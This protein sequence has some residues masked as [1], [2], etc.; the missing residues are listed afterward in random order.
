MIEPVYETSYTVKIPVLNIIRNGSYCDTILFKEY[1]GSNFY[2]D[3]PGRVY[4]GDNYSLLVIENYLAFN[5]TKILLIKDSY[6]KSV[7]PSFA[8]TC[9]E[10][11]VI[12]LRTFEDSILEYVKQNEI[13][14][15]V[16]MYNP[17]VVVNPEFFD[18][19]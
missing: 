4:T 5:N 17:S 10:L 14:C 8:S 9:Q 18:F 13:D 12:D 19:K 1:M 11:H 15:V 3:D 16:V 7:I 6:S 2:N